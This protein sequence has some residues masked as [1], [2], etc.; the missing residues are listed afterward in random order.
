MTQ[1]LPTSRRCI[2]A[3]IAT[4]CAVSPLQAQAV[5]QVVPIKVYTYR[6]ELQVQLQDFAPQDGFDLTLFASNTAGGPLLARL[7]FTNVASSNG[8]VEAGLKPLWNFPGVPPGAYY[9]VMVAGIVATPAVPASA[10]KG[11]VISGG[12]PSV[13]GFGVIDPL[14]GGQVPGQLRLFL[15]TSDGCASTFD[16]EA[17]TTPGGSDIAR[18]S[19]LDKALAGP[20][21]P[22]GHYYVRVRGRN[23]AGLG[24]Y[25]SVL[26]IAV[27]ACNTHLGERT[28]LGPTN[29]KASVAGNNVTLSWTTSAPIPGFPVTYQELL[30]FPGGGYENPVA[31][32]P[33]T[34]TSVSGVVPSGT[35]TV[36]VR[37]G[38]VC[39]AANDYDVIQFVVP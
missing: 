25:S 9:V 3:L 20:T 38:N 32:L 4:L 13:P 18:L 12:C 26:P 6:Q 19:G 39:G 28:P 34:T 17:G 23:T 21:P 37:D 1:I 7:P 14:S 10:W 27:P 31:L 5:G 22:P 30:V 33:A 35:Y 2:V 8:E 24:A 16:L 15:G 11:F 29:L 36:G